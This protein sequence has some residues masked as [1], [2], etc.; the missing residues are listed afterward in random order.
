MCVWV[1]CLHVCL[2]TMCISGA[3]MGQKRA[4]D[5]L[6]LN[7]P[8]P[9]YSGS[10]CMTAHTALNT[11]IPVLSISASLYLSFVKTTTSA[12][13]GGTPGQLSRVVYRAQCTPV[14]T[15]ST[16]ASTTMN[17]IPSWGATFQL[18]RKTAVSKLLLHPVMAELNSIPGKPPLSHLT[19]VNKATDTCLVVCLIC[20]AHS[21]RWRTS[22]CQ[23]LE[24]ALLPLM[25]EHR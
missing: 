14:S 5:H 10:W 2:H 23:R 22:Q 25:K 24:E 21:D 16:A 18:K 9:A 1:F 8:G 12:R 6:E 17:H 20:A 19:L 7:S 15:A 3:Y 13:P 4:T 11:N